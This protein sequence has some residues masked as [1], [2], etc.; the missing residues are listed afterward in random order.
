MKLMA[1]QS[2]PLHLTQPFTPLAANL[3]A[4]L[5]WKL[6]LMHAAEAECDLRVPLG[7]R[8]E[9]LQG[10]LKGWCSIRVNKQY[11]LIFK[12]LKGKV[13]DAYLEPHTYQ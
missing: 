5:D 11:R 1:P 8:F 4:A 10:K 7:N 12:W 3:A 13:I 6:D 9:H 2:R